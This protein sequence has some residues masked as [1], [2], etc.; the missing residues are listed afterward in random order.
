LLIVVT[1]SSFYLPGPW[2]LPILMGIAGSFSLAVLD[3]W[4]SQR[5]PIKRISSPARTFLVMMIATVSAIRVFFVPPRKLWKESTI[6]PSARPAE[7]T[8]R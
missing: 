5:L 4:I 8:T 1:I 3:P 2:R 7:D 6:Q